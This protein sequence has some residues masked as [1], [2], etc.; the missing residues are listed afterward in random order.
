[1]NFSNLPI[2]FA[3]PLGAAAWAVLVGVPVGI[4]A[5]YFLKLRRKPVQVP[6]TLLWRRS[7]EDLHVNSLFQRLRRNLLLF[8]QLAAVLLAMLALLGPRIRGTA[9]E[10]R[11]FVI[12]IDQSASM[13]AT[14][15]EPSRLEKAKEEARKLVDAMGGDDLAMVIA[16]SDRARVVSNYT[17]N[18]GELKRR[19]D[20][21]EPTQATT[22]LREALQVAAGLA[23]PSKMIEGVAATSIVPPRLM[24]YTDGGFPDVEGFSLGNLEPEVVVIGA[25]PSGPDPAAAPKPTADPTETPQPRVSAPSD[26]LAILALQARRNEEKPDEYQVFGRVHN[27]RAEPAEAEAQLYRRDPAKPGDPGT[28]VDALALT[29]PAREDQAFKF[30]LPDLGPSELEVR[31]TVE[32][33]LASDNR[34]YT[35]VGDAR[36]ARILA[37]TEGNK[38]LV[39]TLSTPMAQER[40]EVRVV[41]PA[42]AKTDDLAREAAAGA[43]D[44]IIYDRFRPETPPAANTL[45]FGALPPGPAFAETRELNGPVILDWNVAH[46]LLQYIRDLPTVT[47]LKA[48]G[49]DPPPGSTALID[50]NGGPIAFVVPREGYADAVVAFSLVDGREFNTNWPLKLSFPLF[51]LNAVEYLGNAREASGGEAHQPGQPITIRVDATPAPESVRVTTPA[52]A[53]GTVA[54]SSQGAFLYNDAEQ[55]GLYRVEWEPDGRLSFAVNRFDFRESDL[56]PRGLVPDDVPEAQ[57]DAYKIKIGYSPVTGTRSSAPVR[58]DW[59]KPLALAALVVILVEWYIYNRRIYI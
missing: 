41:T 21:I 19:I 8:L 10:G 13:A 54:R 50:S 47:I 17:G 7:M 3:S 28:L 15:V 1:M 56:A 5:L 48:I 59:W 30:D 38:Y 43:F 57:A 49:V 36:R 40:A 23:N 55:T 31:L 51:L 44:L 18:R 27:F 39:D 37:V 52:G 20:A 2:E 25:P 11:R 42:E 32:D 46:P 26:N 16:F 45:Y 22:S 33:D 58:N 4:I 12:A 14:D 29:I 6:S 34:A 35:Q 9:G 53:S 24:I